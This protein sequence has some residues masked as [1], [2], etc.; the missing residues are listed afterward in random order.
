MADSAAP[1][2]RPLC[3]RRRAWRGRGGRARRSRLSAR[4]LA[5]AAKNCQPCTHSPG[6]CSRTSEGCTGL[7]PAARLAHVGAAKSLSASVAR[8][9]RISAAAAPPSSS[10]AKSC[11][12]A[13]ATAAWRWRTMGKQS[14]QEAQYAAGANR[15]ADLKPMPP[16]RSGKCTQ[17]LVASSASS[18]QF[19]S[20]LRQRRSAVSCAA[21][22][23]AVAAGGSVRRK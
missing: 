19:S 18:C 22:Y 11:T 12:M 16:C 7:A 1:A 4:S 2:P 13:S 6:S 8:Q 14:A 10:L 23:S 17:R 15:A 20:S 21:A 3:E 9:A 5:S